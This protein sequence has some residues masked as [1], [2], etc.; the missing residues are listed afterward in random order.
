MKQVSWTK[1]LLTVTKRVSKMNNKYRIWN[2]K[3]FGFVIDAFERYFLSQDGML[4]RIDNGNVEAMHK[5]DYLI[6]WD[7][8]TPFFSSAN[9]Y[10]Y[11][12]I[13]YNDADGI[14]HTATVLWD[15]YYL[16]FE[17]QRLRYDP[18]GAGRNAEWESRENPSPMDDYDGASGLSIL[19]DAENI[20]RDY[21]LGPV[22]DPREMHDSVVIGTLLEM[23]ILDAKIKKQIELFEVAMPQ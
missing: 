23:S 21:A 16:K 20:L 1:L 11:D 19:P 22:L 18:N 2:K 3:S 7:A 6:V 12:I 15:E 9:P 5:E 8:N 13:A 14:P 4:F 17:F 10:T